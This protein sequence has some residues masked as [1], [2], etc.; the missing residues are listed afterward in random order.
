MKI[1][2]TDFYTPEQLA[3]MGEAG[4]KGLEIIELAKQGKKIKDLDLRGIRM[5]KGDLK[6]A[7]FFNVD[8]SDSNLDSADFSEAELIN[9]NF[10]R[11]VCRNTIFK[12]ALIQ[13]CT[14]HATELVCAN[15]NH[16]TLCESEFI[17][18]NM[19]A[20]DF[21]LIESLECCDFTS[22]NL[23]DTILEGVKINDIVDDAINI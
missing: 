16:A 13:G 14:L 10:G 4:K 1:N 2:L 20:A 15:F 18:A 6:K 17:G 3:E 9:C 12:N 8:F 11:A 5:I 19:F 21:S 22:A 23:K 7:R